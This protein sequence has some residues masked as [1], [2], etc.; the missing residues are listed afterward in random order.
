[1]PSGD[2][3]REEV[4]PWGMEGMRGEIRELGRRGW[5]GLWS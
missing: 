3:K 2:G 1:M 4:V 5:W